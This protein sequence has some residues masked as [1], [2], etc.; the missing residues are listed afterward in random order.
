MER[1]DLRKSSSLIAKMAKYLLKTRINLT[2]NNWEDEKI[3]PLS[4]DT[5][6]AAP[7]KHLVPRQS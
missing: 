4:L 1:Q 2:I 6:C 3:T 7:I 5:N